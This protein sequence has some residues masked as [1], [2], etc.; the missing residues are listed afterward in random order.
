M[1]FR[2]KILMIGMI[3]SYCIGTGTHI[4]DRFDGQVKIIE[5]AKKCFSPEQ[6]E[7]DEIPGEYI[8]F[9]FFVLSCRGEKKTDHYR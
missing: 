6:L 2:H 5:L 7:T 3:R 8:H 9:I 4:A 1:Q